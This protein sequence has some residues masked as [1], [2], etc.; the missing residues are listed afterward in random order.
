MHNGS[1]TMWY[2]VVW[3]A[4]K[5]NFAVMAVTN[6]AGLGLQAGTAATDAAVSLLIEQQV[7]SMKE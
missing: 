3:I 1:N 5:R 6:L 7:K 2:S 4:P